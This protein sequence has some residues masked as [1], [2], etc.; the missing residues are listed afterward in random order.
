MCIAG[1]GVVAS[2]IGTAVSAAAGMAQANAQAS[3]QQ[4]QA[5]IYERQAQIERQT[6]EYEAQRQREKGAR[7]AG[8]QRAAFLASGVSLAGTPTDIIADST[9]ENELDVSAIRYNGTI[10]SQNFSDQAKI[11]RVAAGNTKSAGALSALA[12]AIS[13]IG[14][15]GMQGGFG[16]SVY[17]DEDY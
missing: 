16:G 9:R 7:L 10:K 3:S 4:A 13:G 1:F 8:K 15:I 17:D 2:L 11:Y 14:K 12:P 6:A 5:A